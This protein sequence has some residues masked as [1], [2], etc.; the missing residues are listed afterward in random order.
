MHLAFLSAGGE[1]GRLAPLQL[2]MFLMELPLCSP[3]QCVPVPP[4]LCLP[5][6]FGAKLVFP[7]QCLWFLKCPQVIWVENG[8]N[9]CCVIK[10]PHFIRGVLQNLENQDYF[11]VF[12]ALVFFLVTVVPPKPVSLGNCWL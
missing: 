4:N 12:T 2:F 5:T 9:R 3:C 8:I 6:C 11:Y 10:T 7:S 1:E